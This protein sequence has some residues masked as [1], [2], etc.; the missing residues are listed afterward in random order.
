MHEVLGVNLMCPLRGDV[1]EIL[2]PI[3]SNVNEK[4]KEIWWIGTCHVNFV[5]IYLTVF[6]KT[7]SA[8]G[9]TDD[10]R[11]PDERPRHDSSSAV[12]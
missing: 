3:C 2:Y 8:D 6:Q 12:Q 5:S 9:R 10:G 7:M 1:F 4:E 11:T